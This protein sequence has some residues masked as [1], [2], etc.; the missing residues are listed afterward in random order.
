METIGIKAK[1]VGRLLLHPYLTLASRLGL[2]GVFIFAGVAKLHYA[3]TLV[4]EIKCRSVERAVDRG[5]NSV[6]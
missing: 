1:R 3:D 4:W 5:M 6:E 2:A